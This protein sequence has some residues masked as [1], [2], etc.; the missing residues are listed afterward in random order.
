[1][2]VP[3]RDVVPGPL[4]EFGPG[5][6]AQL[7][8]VGYAP[9]SIEGQ[10]GLMRHLSRWL[11]AQ[12][13]TAVDLDDRTVDRFVAARRR[14]YV[15]FR[16]KR[17]LMPLRAYLVS[18]GVTR[19]QGVEPKAPD[20]ALLEQFARYLSTERALAPETIRSYV[21]QVRPFVAAHMGDEGGWL[22][23]TRRQVAAF[24]VDRAGRER[25]RSAQV[26]ANAL[27]A[28]LRWM[29]WERMI[30]SPLADAVGSVAAPTGT[31]LLKGLSAGEVS[32][33]FAQVFG[34]APAHLRS[35]AMLSLMCRLGLRAGEVARLRLGDIDWRAGVI[36]V[37]GKRGRRDQMPLP[38]D[39]GRSL[40]TYLQRGRPPA[41]AY[42][43]VFL[44]LDAPHRPIGR[45]AV[46]SVVSRALARAGIAGPGAAHRLRHT[47]ACGVLAAGGG[48][49]EAGQLLRHCSPAATQV[50]ARSDLAALGALARPWPI[51][52]TR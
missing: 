52:G 31:A 41:G 39:V 19:G 43:E 8:S 27:R 36:T 21:S 34:D 15:S 3:S 10:L 23:L 16:S 47:A 9:R 49:V 40:V 2:V 37:H 29:W 11:E 17:A 42:R 33:L 7:R 28:L 5:F 25:P 38:V 14:E 44:A 30:A 18:L 4:G 22:S 35:G 32:A 13:L 12:G 46:T 24:V 51:G 45:A 26:R 50:Y 48:L 6:S 20:E 1:M